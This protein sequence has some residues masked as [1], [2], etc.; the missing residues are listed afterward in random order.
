[1]VKYKLDP[2]FS[3]VVENINVILAEKPNT[4]YEELHCV[5][6]N[7]DL[8]TLVATLSVKLPYGY[9]GDLCT[10]GNVLAQLHTPVPEGDGLYEIRVLLYKLGAP[11]D[12]DVP[13][14]HISS[15]VVKVMIDNKVPDVAIS[16]DMVPCAKYKVGDEIKGKFT[17]FDKHIYYYTIAVEPSVAVQPVIDHPG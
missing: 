1:M 11:P 3:N 9:C 7:Y 5:G 14:D 6:L 17:A 2:K 12:S 16:L 15:N 8:N 13:P 4:K 10:K